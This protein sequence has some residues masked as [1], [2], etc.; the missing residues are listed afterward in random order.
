MSYVDLG[1]DKDF[2]IRLGKKGVVLL[3][4]MTNDWVR[5][6]NTGILRFAQN[7][8]LGFLKRFELGD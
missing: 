4:T 2:T 3:E 6:Q 1:L 8:G 5:K 7:D